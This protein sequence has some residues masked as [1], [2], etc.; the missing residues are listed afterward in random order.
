[1]F[2]LIKE[3]KECIQDINTLLE[4]VSEGSNK[5]VELIKAN[6]VALETVKTKKKPQ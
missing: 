1:M 4:K 2:Q 5:T 3:A 6:G